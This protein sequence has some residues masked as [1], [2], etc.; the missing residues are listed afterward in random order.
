MDIVS[1]APTT[2]TVALGRA[3]VAVSGLSLRKL[4]QLIAEYPEL[5]AFA[6]GGSIDAA[7]LV[8]GA[9]QMALAIFAL[10]VNG[11]TRPPWWQLWR[12][13]KPAG[14]V[15]LLAAFDRAATG[16]QIGILDAIVEATFEGE[17]GG[18][19]LKSALAAL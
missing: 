15:D 3:T 12:L 18:P 16:Q 8:V 17:R 4:T 14:E 11:Q 10:G 1:I 13:L 5:L 6:G 2:R 7:A 9:P 19:F